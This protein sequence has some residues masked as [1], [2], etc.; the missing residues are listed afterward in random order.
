MSY[1]SVSIGLVKQVKD[2]GG[3]FG[4]WADEVTDTS[5]WKQLEVLSG[6]R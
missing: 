1:C 6:E 3:F 2:G 5:N 4:I